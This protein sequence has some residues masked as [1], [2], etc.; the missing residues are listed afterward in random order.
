MGESIFDALLAG[1]PHLALCPMS[2]WNA[3]YR[4]QSCVHCPRSGLL[5]DAPRCLSWTR[6]KH[7]VLD[8]PPGI[9]PL[10]QCAIDEIVRCAR[11]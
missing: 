3:V 11:G 7:G 4:G 2:N 6:F 9:P 8:V 5:G 10:K 1:S